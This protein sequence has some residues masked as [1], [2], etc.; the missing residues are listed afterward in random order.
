MRKLI[1]GSVTTLTIHD[2]RL[3]RASCGIVCGMI[4]HSE[5]LVRID[6]KVRSFGLL[7][8]AGDVGNVVWPATLRELLLREC[9]LRDLA[10]EAICKSTSKLPDRLEV[11]DL[12]SNKLTDS[13]A[14]CVSEHFLE[15]DDSKLQELRLDSNLLTAQCLTFLARGLTVGGTSLHTLS[16]A[17]NNL[18]GDGILT[19]SFAERKASLDRDGGGKGKGADNGELL[20]WQIAL[21]PNDKDISS[22]G[23]PQ[24][25]V[26]VFVGGGGS[27]GGG[28]SVRTRSYE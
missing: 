16:L 18:T 8:P 12:C 4:A 15:R 21:N 7:D 24:E 10:V 22:E 9:G 6:L 26:I 27:G 2:H 11:L 20:P 5:Q 17:G 25:C 28:V 19:S 3:S 13:A 23:G 1:L 14:S